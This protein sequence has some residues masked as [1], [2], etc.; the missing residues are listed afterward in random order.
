[1]GLWDSFL[2]ILGI[3][4]EQDRWERL[5]DELDAA[6][7]SM[8][9]EFY[10][11]YDPD[12]ARAE[13]EWEEQRELDRLEWGSYLMEVEGIAK[14]EER[15]RIEELFEQRRDVDGSG[16]TA[17]ERD[18][19]YFELEGGE[20]TNYRYS[21][22]NAQYFAM[23]F[24]AADISNATDM[25]LES[26]VELSAGDKLTDDKGNTF[27]FDGSEFVRDLQERMPKPTKEQMDRAT[28]EIELLI[29]GLEVVLLDGDCVVP[30]AT[31]RG[32]G[33]LTWN[34]LNDGQ[35]RDAL[36][37]VI[38]WEGF[39][40][41]QRADIIRRV[42]DEEEPDFWMDGIEMEATPLEKAIAEVHA[43]KERENTR[44]LG[45]TDLGLGEGWTT[46]GS[47]DLG[48]WADWSEPQRLAVLDDF[49]QWQG[50]DP[51]EKRRILEREVDFSLVGPE[52]QRQILGEL[53][54]Q[55]ETLSVLPA[56][57]T[58]DAP[59]PDGRP[60]RPLTEQLI[61]AALLDVWPSIPAIVDFGIDSSSH[62]G[63]LQYAIRYGEVTPQ[64]LDAAMGNGAKLTE[65]AQRGDNPYRDVTFRT[66]WDEMRL[67]PSNVPEWHD[68]KALFAEIRADEYAARVR[69]YGEADAA[70][71]EQRVRDGAGTVTQLEPLPKPLTDA[72]LEQAV[73]E[74]ER[75]W[76]SN[77]TEATPD[78]KSRFSAI[79]NGKTAP[80][81][82]MEQTT[83]EKSR[84]DDGREM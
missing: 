77:R 39:S 37:A 66:S 14:V 8:R 79:L 45:P 71:Y 25:I 47:V 38:D 6:E 43:I 12:A 52:D 51:A 35:R 19:Y 82:K 84:G 67:E 48:K 41:P 30:A 57:S 83:L 1:M 80:E 74:A 34:D 56:V 40:E 81:V 22:A 65:I 29:G 15:L 59:S 78:E 49:V 64:E 27:L 36:A 18:R 3:E 17:A 7:E 63:A 33:Y 11:S 69:D 54:K 32:G 46:I 9:A 21:D 16:L 55:N 20:V 73:S 5:T 72:E 60:V 13:A 61:N 2:K 4:T 50:I 62:L 23:E 28:N 26:V 76:Q 68:T 70:T 24:Q 10:A 53:W 42:I 58:A 75:S 31:G 44:I